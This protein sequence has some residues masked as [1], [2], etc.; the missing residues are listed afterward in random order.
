MAGSVWVSWPLK[1]TAIAL[2]MLI[3]SRKHLFKNN[4]FDTVDKWDK[5]SCTAE[6]REARTI[7]GIC[8]SLKNPLEGAANVRFGRNVPIPAVNKASKQDIMDP[9]PGLISKKLMTR[10]KFIPVDM[11]NL[12]TTSWIQFMTHDWFSHGP[13]SASRPHKM[14]DGM[15]IKR[16]R[17]DKSHNSKSKTAKTFFSPQ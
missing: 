3:G 16:T 8:N 5:V 6:S 2:V 10:E 12:L 15:S 4:L 17:P 9:P 11:L 14:K 7:T 1:G 13:R